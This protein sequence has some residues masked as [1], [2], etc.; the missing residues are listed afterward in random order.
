MTAPL[1]I[2]AVG[3]DRAVKPAT[4]TTA[5]LGTEPEEL[6]QVAAASD[7]PNDLTEDVIA[8]TPPTMQPPPAA[9]LPLQEPTTGVLPVAA[10]ASIPEDEVAA[11][12]RL[13]GVQPA[14]VP[15]LIENATN[16]LAERGISFDTLKEQ[17]M[18]MGLSAPQAIASL[19]ALALPERF[20]AAADYAPEI[21]RTQE[22]AV[23][24]LVVMAALT[25]ELQGTVPA[26]EAMR[27]ASV[28]AEKLSRL[29]PRDVL[30]VAEA[31]PKLV[32]AMAGA[33][34][35]E[36]TTAIAALLHASPE[37]VARVARQGSEVTMMHEARALAADAHSERLATDRADNHVRGGRL[38]AVRADAAHE[39]DVRGLAV[40]AAF[41]TLASSDSPDSARNL[42]ARAVA[43]ASSAAP[44]IILSAA[45]EGGQSLEKTLDKLEPFLDNYDRLRAQMVNVNAVPRAELCNALHVHLTRGSEQFYV[46]LL[47]MLR[48]HTALCT[49]PGSRA[50][51][52][53]LR[54]SRVRG[55]TS[56]WNEGA[57]S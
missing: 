11:I 18:Q 23:L 7:V 40:A 43:T 47:K 50:L 2:A 41:I 51:Q 4:V 30:F 48:R 15:R 44:R 42:Y 21:P 26:P 33:G 3:A 37:T 31:I 10:V 25:T 22:Q 46:A 32:G 39:A 35:I 34:R 54:N 13:L 19:I 29:P 17:A 56:T 49:R 27:F 38:E 24:S 8:A 12:A 55:G 9:V 6:A 52:T 28:A 36:T 20:A 57:L 14:D 16:I 45:R 5:P 53:A 1:T